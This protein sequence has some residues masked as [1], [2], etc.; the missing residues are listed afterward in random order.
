[1]KG[2]ALIELFDPEAMNYYAG[3]CG[4][5]LARAHARSGDPGAITNRGYR[6]GLGGIR[7]SERSMPPHRGDMFGREVPIGQQLPREADHVP[8]PAHR[9]VEQPLDTAARKLQRPIR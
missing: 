7:L 4:W 3:V 2:S 5:T 8:V 1:M 6:G 9:G